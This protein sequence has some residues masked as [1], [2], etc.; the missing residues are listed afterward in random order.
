[1]KT[2]TITI[3]QSDVYKEVAKAT[4]YT[5]SKLIDGDDKARDRIL[6]VDDDFKELGRFWDETIAAMEEFLKS[7]LVKS[8]KNDSKNYELE[9]EVSA[10]WDDALK[11]S[12]QA[13]LRSYFISSIIGKWF[14]F[15]N[16]GESNEYLVN[17]ASLLV[18]AE[19]MLYARKRPALPTE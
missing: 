12:V 15:A 2:I 19:R 11:D 9:L 13:T 7:L 14:N 3:G 17:A 6:A 1:M 18:D 16:K 5:G 8:S 4:D 10:S